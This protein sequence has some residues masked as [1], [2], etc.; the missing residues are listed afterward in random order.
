MK[1]LH[2]N[3]S[4]P[5]NLQRALP[6]RSW[7]LAVVMAGL[8]V[9][10]GLLT[11][12]GW[13]MHIDSLKSGAVGLAPMNP[14]TALLFIASGSALALTAQERAHAV[15][16]AVRLLGLV[17]ASVGGAILGRYLGLWNSSL[18]QL[19][20]GNEL[21]A[22]RM[23]PNAALYFTLAG[24][25]LITLDARPRWFCRTS[26]LMAVIV[27]LGA[28]VSLIGYAYGTANLYGIGRSS[29]R[30]LNAA[31]LFAVMSVGLLATRH[32]RTFFAILSSAD[33]GGKIARRLL[34]AAIVI[35][36]ILGLLRVAGQ[37]S[38][39][40]DTE[41]GT[42]LMVIGTVF[43]LVLAILITAHALSNSD[44]RRREAEK[45]IQLY[46][47]IV[48]HI[49]IGLNIFRLE[50]TNDPRSLRFIDTNPSAAELL[51][52]ETRRLLGR[53]IVEAFP[54]VGERELRIYAEAARSGEAREIP[55]VH[56]GDDRV[57]ANIWSVKAFPL[58]DQC[59]GLA[60]ENISR[61]K[62]AED[63][64]RRLNEELEQRVEQRTAAL[65]EAN[66]DLTHKNQENEMFVYSVSHDL[67]SPLVSLQGFSKE[68]GVTAQ[69]LST[70]FDSDSV[71]ADTSATAR[72]LVDGD[73]QQSLKFIQ[74]AVLRLGNIID[75]L[76]R[77]SRV[78]RVEYEIRELDTKAIVERVVEAT[79]GELFE[80][81]LDVTIH[82]L[83]R[84]HGDATA[85][86]QVFANLFGNAVKYLDPSRRGQIEIGAVTQT[87]AL[88]RDEQIF[89]IRD[90]GLGIPQACQE[91][92]FQA[93]Q[94][95]HPKHA[96]GDGMGLAIVRR[97]VD[98]HGGRV[99]VE[100][101]EGQGST[102]FFTLPIRSIPVSYVLSKNG[103][104]QDEARTNGHLVGRG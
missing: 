81:G 88:S 55:E 4:A 33:A 80:R 23:A 47:D 48:R 46:A 66:R 89:Y 70:L 75:A 77:L 2:R 91:K 12:V 87:T 13:L 34:P 6:C 101:A 58:P 84:C 14:L 54:S 10:G 96:P 65:A 45:A 79:S 26:E 99:W 15:T 104:N 35:P 92:V 57:A 17:V 50:D 67:R 76:L 95:V 86:E 69:E 52:T 62:A 56:Y 11:L 27:A 85:V 90:N 72:R 102:F 44:S 16:W 100:S 25:S 41:F 61:R 59:V 103:G 97:I 83:P 82:E 21:G 24:F 71:P 68:L 64:V 9:G 40:Y 3:D 63:Q 53:T 60:F 19:L 30:A 42:A 38:G 49:P 37:R 98:R 43:L 39:W 51:G 94:R 31:I 1:P 18:D 29:P 8:V 93:F 5:S 74:S 73:I 36:I 32:Q 7:V 28:T 22:G 20:F 78:G